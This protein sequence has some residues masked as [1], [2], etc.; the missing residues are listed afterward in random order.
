MTTTVAWWES[1]CTQLLKVGNQSSPCFV[2]D[3]PCLQETIQRIKTLQSAD[4]AFYAMKACY[5]PEVLKAIYN[6]GLG[7]ECVSPGELY[8][9]HRLFP[10]I[11]AD[12]IL[13]TPNFVPKE[14]YIL[15]YELASHVTVGNVRV[16][17]LWS[18]VFKQRDVILRIDPGHGRGHHKHVRTAGSASKFGIAPESLPLVQEIC[19]LYDIRITGLHAHVGSGILTPDTWSSTA[20]ALAS[21]AEMFPYTTH[22]NV[23]GGFGV[24]EKPGSSP[25][26]LHV[27]EESL[28]QFRKIHPQFEL[29][30][31]PGRYLVAESGVLLTRVTQ[32]KYKGDR[33]YIGVE[34]GM[35]SLIRPALY[36]SNHRIFNLSS[37]HSPLNITADIVGPICETGDIIGHACQLPET[38]EGDFL[39][40]ATAGAYG[41]VMS[42][43]YNMR[44]PACEVVL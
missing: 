13:F 7:F 36:G 27:L 33:C 1:K 41:R 29:W 26:D 17:E 15:G 10:E 19:D 12:Q 30:I 39:L 37:L 3:I 22:L 8:E 43:N 24:P 40:I 6:S 18:D 5:N 38:S 42:S 21:I 11:E 9:I 34:T 35:N 32:I 25:L 23:G 4:R 20:Y 2:Y 28:Q 31:E 44:E 14:E 16:L